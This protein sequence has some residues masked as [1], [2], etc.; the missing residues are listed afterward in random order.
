M[1]YYSFYGISCK[2]LC[3]ISSPIFDFMC[4]RALEIF[5]YTSQTPLQLAFQIVC[6]AIRCIHARLEFGSEVNGREVTWDIHFASGNWGRG[7]MEPGAFMPPSQVNMAM[8]MSAAILAAQFR[9]VALS[10]KAQPRVYFLRLHKDLAS[11]LT[12]C[13]KSCSAAT[14]LLG[15]VLWN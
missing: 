11:H 14:S 5:K 9:S 12:P 2:L 1:Y 3:W 6:S 10:L 4:Y 7:S 15:S 8:A 13:C